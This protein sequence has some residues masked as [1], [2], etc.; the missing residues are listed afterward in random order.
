MVSL[1]IKE[2]SSSSLDNS[3]IV[4]KLS[5]ENTFDALMA[6]Q[7]LFSATHLVL[8]HL[9][10][11]NLIILRN[12]ISGYV[13]EK[14]QTTIVKPPVGENSVG[15]LIRRHLNSQQLSAFPDALFWYSRLHCA[16]CF[17]KLEQDEKEETDHSLTSLNFQNLVFELFLRRA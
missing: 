4:Y 3:T 11:R 12:A 10:E 2:F 8:Q 17:Q 1:G 13:R 14:K 7:L 15:A 6:I 5:A 9:C 16:Q